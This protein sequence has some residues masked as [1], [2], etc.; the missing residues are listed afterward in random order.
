M[1]IIECKEIDYILEI[2]KWGN[3]SKAA[4]ALYI[5]QP[6]LTKYLKHLEERVGVE[7][8]AHGSRPLMP[9]PAGEV[10]LRYA[11]KIAAL[12]RNMEKD[13]A[14]WKQNS[15]TLA[16]GFANNWIR[17]HL[18]NVTRKMQLKEPGVQIVVNEMRSNA[19]EKL[20]ISCE[21]DIGFVTF[22][23]MN[24]QIE[25]RLLMEETLLLAVPAT[26]P[27]ASGGAL[28]SAGEFPLINL[29]LFSEEDFILREA[30]SRFRKCTDL[31]FSQT[32]FNPKIIT[33][34]SSNF[35]C[36]ELAEAG[37]L[38][39]I[40]TKTFM[41]HLKKADSM[42]FFTAGP[43]P[44]K[45]QVGLAFRRGDELSEPARELVEL[46]IQEVAG[47]QGGQ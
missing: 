29:N 13:M 14:S 21:L 42:R 25:T 15:L 10:Y 37:N 6:A 20:L 1:S 5:S 43:K 31:L 12:E 17:Q 18:L 33:T 28:C 4:E 30:G 46:L 34:G 23:T 38:C 32:D 45:L 2:A 24:E 36:M 11:R 19:I 44:Q 40:T 35:S 26:H 9:T 41:S 8:F 39:C 27:L 3:I 47:I 16:V 22:P 7:L